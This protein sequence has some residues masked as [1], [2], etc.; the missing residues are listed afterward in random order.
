MMLYS[1]LAKAE[2][3]KAI[4]KLL[5]CRNVYALHNTQLKISCNTTSNSSMYINQEMTL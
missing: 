3:E 5:C 1:S 2:Q 4:I